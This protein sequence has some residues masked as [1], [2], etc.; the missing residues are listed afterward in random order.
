MSWFFRAAAQGHPEAAYNLAIGHLKGHDLGFE[1]IIFD[2][3]SIKSFC[4]GLI[5]QCIR[6]DVKKVRNLI[7]VSQIVDAMVMTIITITERKQWCDK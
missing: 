3:L 6:I 5:F 7:K 4:K 1:V 2:I